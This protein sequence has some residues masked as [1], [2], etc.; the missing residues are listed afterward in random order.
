L[1]GKVGQANHVYMQMNTG[2]EY[3]GLQTTLDEIV[4][5]WGNDGTTLLDSIH[6]YGAQGNLLAYWVARGL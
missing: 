4:A 2:L 1:K 6:L 3:G 5:A